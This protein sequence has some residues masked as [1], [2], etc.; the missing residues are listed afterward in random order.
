MR[1]RGSELFFDKLQ[2]GVFPFYFLPIKLF[3][4]EKYMIFEEDKG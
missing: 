2:G 4:E 1:S 3:D